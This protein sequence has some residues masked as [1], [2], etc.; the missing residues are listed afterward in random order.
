MPFLWVFSE[1]SRY[2][3]VRYVYYMYARVLVIIGLFNA[4]NLHPRLPKSPPSETD[5]IFH[6]IQYRQVLTLSQ[7]VL[8]CIRILSGP[9]GIAC[10]TL[11]R[12]LDRVAQND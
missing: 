11:A 7:G 9:C 4:P 12:S 3:T 2:S 5:A 6:S 1:L 8:I 10:E